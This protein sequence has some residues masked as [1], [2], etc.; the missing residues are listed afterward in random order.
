MGLAG[1]LRGCLHSHRAAVRAAPS[2]LL[3]LGPAPYMDLES[4]SLLLM[5]TSKSLSFAFMCLYSLYSSAIGTRSSFW[6]FLMETKG[7]GAEHCLLSLLDDTVQHAYYQHGM[8]NLQ[9][10][11]HKTETLSSRRISVAKHH[12]V[13]KLELGLDKQ[14]PHKAPCD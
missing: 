13:S 7:K 6:T 9:H 14:L 2:A 1:P 3:G 5:S 8:S 11:L 4:V 12:L 10:Y